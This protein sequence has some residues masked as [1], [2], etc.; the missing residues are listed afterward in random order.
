METGD[1]HAWPTIPGWV[2]V[3]ELGGELVPFVRLAYSRG[4]EAVEFTLP[5]SGPL[6]LQWWAAIEDDLESAWVPVWVWFEDSDDDPLT[7]VSLDPTDGV[8]PRQLFMPTSARGRLAV[9]RAVTEAVIQLTGESSAVAAADALEAT[10]YDVPDDAAGPEPLE[11]DSGEGDAWPTIPT[12]IWLEA[13]AG[14][15]WQAQA[16]LRNTNGVTPLPVEVPVA[17]R[18]LAHFWSI[19][20]SAMRQ[21][22]AGHP[23]SLTVPAWLWVYVNDGQ[24]DAW[25]SLEPVDGVTATMLALPDDEESLANLRGE[26]GRA[27]MWLTGHSTPDA[28][29][30]ELTKPAP[31]SRKSITKPAK[32][33]PKPK[34]ATNKR[35]RKASSRSDRKMVLPRVR[36]VSGGLPGLG[37]R[38]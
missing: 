33:E 27:M 38:R 9:R 7:C 36:I 22:E 6:L 34:A 37:R 32:P 16:T 1:F 10:R 8:A 11:D 19:I 17:S 24:A 13:D 18:T 26:I 29:L 21:L 30:R 20:S 12:W 5:H 23:H 3:E 28:A 25:I 31:Q 15:E 14:G 35:P 4:I 2:W